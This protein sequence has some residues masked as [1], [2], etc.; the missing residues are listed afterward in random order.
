MSPFRLLRYLALLALLLGSKQLL[1]QDTTKI[2][3]SSLA[4]FYD[5]SLEQLDSVKA[6]G[7]SSELEKFINSL[8]AVATGKSQSTRKLPSVVSL[9]T[10]EQIRNQGARDL[11]D[12]LRMVP[13]FH[14]GLDIDGRIGLGCGA[15][16][17]TRERCS[18]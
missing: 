6:S 4:A 3:S 5:M 11:I 2:D 8:M 9:I 1:A 17:R 14:F 18:C 12:V 7:V 16:G 13:G 15:T 10:K